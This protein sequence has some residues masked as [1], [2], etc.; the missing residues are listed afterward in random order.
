MRKLSLT[1]ALLLALLLAIPA[2]AEGILP[3][4]QTPPPEITETV[5]FHRVMNQSSTPSANTSSD[6][7]YY[8]NYTGVSYDT[9]LDFGR[10]LAQ[11][12]FSLS[13]IEQSEDGT[14]AIIVTVSK[15]AASLTIRYNAD[16]RGLTI[17]YPPRVLA[18]EVNPDS[19]YVI[20]ESQA[21]IL[22]ELTQAISLHAVTG[23]SRPDPELRSDGG[24]VYK[25]YSVPYAAY[26][27]FSQKLG[28]E[29][30]SLVSSE[31]TEDG[32]DRAVVTDGTVE[33]IIDYH[34]D[35]QYARVY[36]P[37][38]A[39]P[40]DRRLFDDYEAV[41]EGD[42]IDVLE[43]VKVTFGGWEFVDVF[44]SSSDGRRT[45]EDGVK[46]AL[47]HMDFD[48]YRPEDW[49]IGYLMPTRTLY[50][51][52]VAVSD[53]TRFGEYEYNPDDSD[54]NN[55][56]TGHS[57]IGRAQFQAAIGLILTEEQAEHPENIAVTFYSADKVTPY[58]YYLQAP[59]A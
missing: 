27:R 32:Y 22:P 41:G 39:H 29:G 45:A 34:Q 55:I 12:G 15:D 57:F 3:V 2:S 49:E 9:Y 8:Y 4:L 56:Y 5:S 54:L 36:Y 23:L 47:I 38:F 19:P 21:S 14:G 10:A 58:V 31:K 17:T 42:T 30:F 16:T 59:E 24:Y 11:E 50:V 35:D 7:G 6:G 1:L 25:Y 44:Y 13:G 37:Q 51:D 20:D 52:G 48:Y 28:E 18:E 53:M 43:N 26:A 40:R 46:L 33:L